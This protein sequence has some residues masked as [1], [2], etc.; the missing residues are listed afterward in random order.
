VTI[1]TDT[2]AISDSFAYELTVSNAIEGLNLETFNQASQWGS[3][4][5]LQNLVVM[6]ALAKYPDDP[7]ETFLGENNTVSVLGQEFGHRWLTF[8]LFRDQNGRVSR[9]LLGRDSAHWSFFVDSDS[10]V[11]E[12]NDIEDL[13][14]GNFRTVAAV[15]RYSLLDQYAMGLVDQSQVPPFFYVQNPTNVTPRRT[16]RSAP[17]V[18]VTFSGTRR[19]VTIDD[20]IAAN[21]ARVPSAADSPREYRQAFLYVTS[22]GREVASAE[23]AKIDRIRIAWDQFLSEATDS[24]L[25]VDTRLTRERA[26]MR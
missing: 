19:D 20:V 1:F 7:R 18:G 11:M 14:G 25:R 4:G 8:L 2:A 17:Q 22:P 12:G 9:Q 16:A 15:T 6:D 10:S 5:R 13:G 21:G 26:S 23:I 3:A 24:R